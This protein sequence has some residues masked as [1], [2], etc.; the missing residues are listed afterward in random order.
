MFQLKS[1]TL[2]TCVLLLFPPRDSLCRS[3]FCPVQSVTDY[4]IDMSAAAEGKLAGLRTPMLAVSAMDDP[5]MTAGGL[6]IDEMEK[7]KDLYVLLT[8]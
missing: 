4:Y 7:T 1:A 8:R 3:F 2:C 5:I 6:P